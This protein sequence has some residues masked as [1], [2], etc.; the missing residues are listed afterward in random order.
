MAQHGGYGFKEHQTGKLSSTSLLPQY[1]HKAILEGAKAAPI[2]CC[3]IR[4]LSDK[5]VLTIFF[6][7]F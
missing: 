2:A 1:L 4:F 7:I 6:F 3:G 5:S